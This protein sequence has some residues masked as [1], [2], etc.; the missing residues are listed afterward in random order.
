MQGREA[1]KTLEQQLAA[2]AYE[3]VK[4]RLNEKKELRDKYGIWCV[5]TG[6]L[7]RN[8]GLAQA[9]AFLESK[10]AKNDAFKWL[11][12]DLNDTPG[13]PNR[14]GSLLDRVT[15]NY[16]VADYVFATQRIQRV[17][18]YFKRFAVSVLGADPTTREEGEGDSEE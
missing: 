8:C 11:L 6:Q 13:L 7:V 12:C 1:L 18:V 5:G 9:L 10:G 2:Y 4:E 17:L 3:K 15:T 16:D 14:E